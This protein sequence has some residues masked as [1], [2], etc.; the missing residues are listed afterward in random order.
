MICDSR[1]AGRSSVRHD[2]E[3]ELGDHLCDIASQGGNSRRLIRIDGVLA[4]HK[5]VILH[6]RTATRGIDDDSVKSG[7]DALSFPR[8]DVGPREGKCGC[9]LSEMMDERAAATAAACH[10]NVAAMAG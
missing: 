7:T 1:P 8:I 10:H 6:C 9:F 5:T 2:D 3:T 4:Q